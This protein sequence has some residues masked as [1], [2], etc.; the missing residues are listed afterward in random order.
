MKTFGRID[1]IINNAGYNDNCGLDRSPVD[2]MQ[3][4]HYNHSQSP[5]LK[6][7]G[8]FQILPWHLLRMM[9]VQNSR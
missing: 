7:G 2:F 9:K 8:C 4:V 1:I 3:S 6:S 5:G